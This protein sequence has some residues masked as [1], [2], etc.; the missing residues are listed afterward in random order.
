M[1]WVTKAGYKCQN[2]S[3]NFHLPGRIFRIRQI[4]NKLVTYYMA[5]T[6]SVFDQICKWIIYKIMFV[7]D[8]DIGNYIVYCIVML[9][10]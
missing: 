3:V 8:I 10:K 5:K 1:Y 6:Y 2:W 7:A 9:E 4:D